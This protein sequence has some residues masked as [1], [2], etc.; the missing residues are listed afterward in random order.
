MEDVIQSSYIP[1]KPDDIQLF[2]VRPTDDSRSN[3]DDDIQSVDWQDLGEQI[4]IDPSLIEISPNDQEPTTA[5]TVRVNLKD[6]R[7]NPMG[8]FV[9]GMIIRA[10]YPIKA[11]KVPKDTEFVSA[12]KYI[13]NTYPVGL[14]IE[15][16]PEGV[17]IP[18]MHIRKKTL[19]GKEVH[20]LPAEGEYEITLFVE[21]VGDSALENIEIRDV[22]PTNFEYS[23]FSIEPT[24]YDNMEG[25]DLL[26]WKVNKVNAGEKLQI[27]FK[28]TGRGDYKA[29]DA[30]F[31]V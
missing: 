11:F 2:V 8:M 19:K 29:S 30:Q 28:I 12:V 5:H 26:V 10:K 27:I 4:D 7:N 3:K 25:K 13:A 23:D 9:P 16:V 18:V 6:L 21:N 24:Q 31:S 20:A 17:H 22:V 14:P 1:P 15:V